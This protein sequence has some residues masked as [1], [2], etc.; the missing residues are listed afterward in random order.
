MAMLDSIV[1]RGD[2]MRGDLARQCRFALVIESFRA[3]SKLTKHVGHELK[4]I[5]VSCKVSIFLRRV[6]KDGYLGHQEAIAI[7]IHPRR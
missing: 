7:I 5:I 4:V 2:L 1:R 3:R 6:Y